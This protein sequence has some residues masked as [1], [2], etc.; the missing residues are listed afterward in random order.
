MHLLVYYVLTG[1]T[2]TDTVSANMKDFIK[3]GLS[4]DKSLRFKDIDEL[5]Q[6]F[7]NIKSI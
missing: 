2:N 4:S 7:Q 3:K 6:A 5:R 1:K